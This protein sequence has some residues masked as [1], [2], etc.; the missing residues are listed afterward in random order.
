MRYVKHNAEGARFFSRQ[1]SK[2]LGEAQ[3]SGIGF[4]VA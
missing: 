1:D 4:S 3:E 2:E